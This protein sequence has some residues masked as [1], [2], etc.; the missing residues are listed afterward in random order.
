MELKQNLQLRLSQQLVMTPQLQQAIRLLQLSRLELVDEIRKELDN[1]PVLVEEDPAE[2]TRKSQDSSQAGTTPEGRDRSGASDEEIFHNRSE[3][4]RDTEKATRE[5]DW[6]KFLENRNQQNSSFNRA[7]GFDDLPPIEQNL[8][9]PNN[10][11]DHLMWQLQMSD[12][13][14]E[15]RVFAELVIGNLDEKGYLD[16][17]GVERPDGTRTPD[18]TIE[19]LAEEAG[20]HEE[21]APLVLEMIQNFDPI[22][23][24][25]RD[26]RECLLIQAKHFGYDEIEVE[27]IEKHI[28]HLEKHNYQAIAR[29]MKIP[30]EEVYE[31]AKEI[32]KLE[33]R[34]A[35]NFTD[36][37]E[38]SIGITPD[39]YVIKD[40]EEF[41]VLDND[42][43]VQRLFINEALTK[44]L[45]ADKA[46]KE[47][48]GEKLRNAQ[49]LIRAIEQRRKTIIR[50]AEAIVEKQRD[51]FEQGVSH[52]KPMILRDVA[53]AVGMHESTISRVTTNKYMHTPN[54]LFELKYF[55]NSSIRRVAD[56]DI[57]SESVK[58]AIKKLI[59]DEDKAKPLSDQAIVKELEKAHGIK[60]ARRTVAKYRE[61]LGI[62]ASSKRKKLF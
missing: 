42:R 37:D 30:L 57:A 5:V 9:K 61:M 60:I 51:F 28:G 12:F 46:A 7:G 15:E 10:L 17:K 6:E 33:S 25:A 16:L 53:E 8:T 31:A 38:R 23:V 32:Q 43:G 14:A 35:R 47:F 55:F 49:W 2:R 11:T 52:L 40:G 62:L 45:L 34:P 36:T 1:N 59:E 27:I 44:Q 3:E 26:L 41:V 39:V 54:G 13:V 18:L 50:V 19:D 4:S 56:E 48:V 21:D 22:G 20:L 29:D 58:Q 24:A